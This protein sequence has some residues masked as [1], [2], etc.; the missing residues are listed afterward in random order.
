MP[1]VKSILTALLCAIL[2]WAG[3]GLAHAQ[4]APQPKLPTIEL[5]A[6]MCIPEGT[7]SDETILVALARKGHPD[8]DDPLALGALDQGPAQR[9]LVRRRHGPT[10]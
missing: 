6:G 3:P 10:S 2:T 1:R 5:G 8:E 9:L 7:R 4:V